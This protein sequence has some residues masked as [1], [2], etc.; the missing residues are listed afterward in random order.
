MTPNHTIFDV[1]HPSIYLKKF[2]PDGRFF[3]GFN[4]ELQIVHIFRYRGV[5]PVGA[6]FQPSNS[7]SAAEP[8]SQ[9]QHVIQ[10][11]IFSTVLREDFRIRVVANDYLPHSIT[12]DFCLFTNDSRFVI[13]GEYFQ[14]NVELL[15]VYSWLIDWLIDWSMVR[16]FDRLIVWLIDW[17]IVIVIGLNFELKFGSF[18]LVTSGTSDLMDDVGPEIR[19]TNESLPLC[20]RNPLEDYKFFLISLAKGEISDRLEFAVDKIPVHH[21]AGVY[22]QDNVLWILIDS[23]SGDSCVRGMQLGVASCIIL[24]LFPENLLCNQSINQPINQ[25]INQSINQPINQSRGHLTLWSAMPWLSL[26]STV[27]FFKHFSLCFCNVFYRFECDAAFMKYQLCMINFV[28]SCSFGSLGRIFYDTKE[29][30]IDFQKIFLL[31]LCLILL[32]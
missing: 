29:F 12:K 4:A 30:F 8:A 21:C 10:R 19:R 27:M 25:S 9:S 2:S 31:N 18:S 1:Q 3:V 7:G 32:F 15:R 11:D 24:W 5:G 6:F 17:L 26:D 28:F 13:V 16:L 22:L 23:A 14:A 20:N